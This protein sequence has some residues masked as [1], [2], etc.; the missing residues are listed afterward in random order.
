[1][2]NQ[3]GGAGGAGQQPGGVQLA[4]LTGA[5]M[6]NPGAGQTS[7]GAGSANPQQQQQKAK[8]PGGL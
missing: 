6:S 4:S 5:G 2:G 1:M 3:A 8:L 7:G